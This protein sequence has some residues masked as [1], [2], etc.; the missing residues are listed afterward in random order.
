MGGVHYVVRYKKEGLE[1]LGEPTEGSAE[2]VFLRIEGA[3]KKEGGGIY[4]G[5]ASIAFTTYSIVV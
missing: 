4:D 1:E 5:H 2:V 3:G